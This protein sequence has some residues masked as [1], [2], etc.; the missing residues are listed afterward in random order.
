MS[1]EAEHCADCSRALD[2]PGDYQQVKRGN[3]IT[4]CV[5]RS[6]LAK[7]WLAKERALDAEEVAA[8]QDKKR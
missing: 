3:I 7:A 8:W 4:V 1:N 2:N 5:C 6:C